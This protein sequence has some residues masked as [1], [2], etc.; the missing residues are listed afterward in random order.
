MGRAYRGRIFP[1][2]DVFAK[3]I[4]LIVTTTFEEANALLNEMLAEEAFRN[5]H[6]LEA[7]VS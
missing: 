2:L 4:A 6:T 7:G 1:H 5:G 3:G